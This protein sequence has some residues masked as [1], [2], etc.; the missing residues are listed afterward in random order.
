MSGTWSFNNLY[1]INLIDKVLN[2][3]SNR[4]LKSAWWKLNS[5][6]WTCFHWEELLDL[7]IDYDDVQELFD[8]R[9]NKTTTEELIYLLNG[10]IKNLKVEHSSQ[11]EDEQVR[12]AASISTQIKDVYGNWT[13]VAGI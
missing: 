11:D 3:I 5:S 8:G 1:W 6:W 10:K 12:E 7:D 9:R 13:V 2:N 4:T